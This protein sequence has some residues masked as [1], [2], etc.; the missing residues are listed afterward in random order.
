MKI[1]LLSHNHVVREF[2]GLGADKA[3]AK[4]D[5]VESVADIDIDSYDIFFV[6]DRG[7]YL[8]QCS[9]LITNLNSCKTVLLYSKADSNHEKFDI[10]IKKP[11]LPSDIKYI[12]EN[13][14]TID[15]PL[16]GEQI[17]NLN[18]IDEIKG[19]LDDEVYDKTLPIPTLADRIKQTKKDIK[20]IEKTKKSEENMEIKLLN[21]IT[22]MEPKKIRK[23]LSGAEVTIS[24]KFPKE[25]S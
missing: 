18:D 4:F 22:K 12:I 1:L 3:D 24:I 23:L 9:K 16:Y 17:L 10:E 8:S 25:R 21:A 11:F 5:F 14:D 2:V 15:E 20:K 6:D 19:L 13:S 7:D